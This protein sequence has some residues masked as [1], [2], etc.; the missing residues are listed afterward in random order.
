MSAR[1]L[2]PT[3]CNDLTT[4]LN[5]SITSKKLPKEFIATKRDG[6]MDPKKEEVD[7][8]H[9]KINYKF[10]TSKPSKDNP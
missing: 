3:E 1:Q 6:V 2:T 4:G 5:F 9:I 10:K 8:I 7:S